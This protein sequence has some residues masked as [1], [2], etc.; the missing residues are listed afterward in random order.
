MPKYAMRSDK[1]TE[2]ANRHFPSKSSQWHLGK[3][4]PP[5][6]RRDGFS[7]RRVLDEWVFESG[8][9]NY[10]SSRALMARQM[11]TFTRTLG[12]KD[13]RKYNN[14]YE[15]E[16]IRTQGVSKAIVGIDKP[17]DS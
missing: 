16:K 6:D 8:N 3:L 11:V 13:W 12:I 5:I 9:I 15:A 1:W 4:K 14:V 2:E 10:L 17:N 7:V